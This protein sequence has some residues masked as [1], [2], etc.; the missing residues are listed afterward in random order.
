MA[1][2]LMSVIPEA[3]M[4]VGVPIGFVMLQFKLVVQLPFPA[5]IVHVGETG[6]NV[7]VIK[8]AVFEFEVEQVNEAGHVFTK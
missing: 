7:P 5:V 1:V 2:T 4:A 8:Y 3:V 6:L